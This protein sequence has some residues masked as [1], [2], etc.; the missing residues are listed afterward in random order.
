MADAWR[1]GEKGVE[2]HG[3][4]GTSKGGCAAVHTTAR[5]ETTRIQN[6]DLNRLA[7]TAATSTR[8]LA[9]ISDR[10]KCMQASLRLHEVQHAV[11]RAMFSCVCA[12]G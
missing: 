5:G 10:D 4:G 7:Q 8:N 9:S 2:G 12:L 1:L 3:G 6:D 11:A